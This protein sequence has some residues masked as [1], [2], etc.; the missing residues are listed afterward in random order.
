MLKTYGRSVLVILAVAVT[1][2][3]N[4]AATLLPING[5][6]TAEISDGF[7][8][9]FMPAGYVFS[10]WGLIYIGLIAF[11]WYQAQRK[12]RVAPWLNVVAP[13]FVVSSVANIGWILLW[14]YGQVN[15]SLVAMLVLLGSLIYIYD[16][17]EIGFY[18]V[19]SLS[20]WCVHAP[21]SL[22]LGWISVATIV[23][24]TVVV[25]NAGLTEIVGFG[26]G[27][28]AAVLALIAGGLAAVAVISRRDFVFAGVIVWAL[29]GLIVK[30]GNVPIMVI[31]VVMAMALIALSAGYKLMMDGKEEE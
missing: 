22:Y 10:I 25:Y 6:T 3:V 20:Y 28:W 17:L 4:L 5:R 26:G 11:A 2:I 1:I 12:A 31:G 18:P 13:A 8:V 30:F 29:A 21:F 15:L 19:S 14:H 9:Y 23:N 27:S 7:P 16:K 24:V